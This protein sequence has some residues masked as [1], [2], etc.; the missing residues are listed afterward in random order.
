MEDK[1]LASGSFDH[2][3]WSIDQKAGQLVATISYGSDV[4]GGSASLIL[5]EKGALDYLKVLIPGQLDDAIINMI[6]PL[7]GA[8]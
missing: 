2:G 6:E 1:N 5:K 4:I 8:V 3:S 7:L